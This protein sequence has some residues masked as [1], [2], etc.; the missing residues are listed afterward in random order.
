MD[1]KWN[2]QR[3]ANLVNLVDHLKT[4]LTQAPVLAF[5]D[6]TLPFIV[7]T[8]ASNHGLG[9][10]L[11]QKKDGRERIL[12]YASRTLHPTEQNDAN[13]SSFKLELLGLKWAVTEKFT[14]RNQVCGVYR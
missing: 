12:A 8:D 9:A 1:V 6:F 13:Y 14:Y 5:A 2:G 10:V 3:S 11:A 7:Y 4:V